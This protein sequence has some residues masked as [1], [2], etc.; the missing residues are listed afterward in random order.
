M[1][2]TRENL[3][4]SLEQDITPGADSNVSSQREKGS[5]DELLQRFFSELGHSSCLTNAEE[6]QLTS[7]AQAS[8]QQMC[9]LLAQGPQQETESFNKS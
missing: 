6:Y 8:W 9:V 5:Y 4:E 2:N 7:R 3:A 1:R